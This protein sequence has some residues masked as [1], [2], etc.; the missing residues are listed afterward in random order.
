VLEAVEQLGF[1]ELAV[2]IGLERLI[3]LVDRRVVQFVRQP[4]GY[5]IRMRSAERDSPVANTDADEKYGDD[6]QEVRHP[7][8]PLVVTAK[9]AQCSF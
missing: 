2:V 4:G 5:L 6:Q 3:Y 9:T 8:Y 1:G 7:P